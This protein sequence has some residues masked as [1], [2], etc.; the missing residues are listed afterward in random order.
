MEV[1]GDSRRSEV[2]RQWWEGGKKKKKKG[3]SFLP[4]L[5]L[6]RTEKLEAELGGEE[7]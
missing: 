1:A 7:C 2:G 5:T 6:P 3:R 4:R